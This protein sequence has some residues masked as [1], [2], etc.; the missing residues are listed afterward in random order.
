MAREDTRVVG[1]GMPHF[2]RDKLTTFEVDHMTLEFLG[3]DQV[4]RTLAG[5]TCTPETRE[6][7]W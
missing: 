2:D 3:K 6:E 4:M 7:F 5:I 1:V